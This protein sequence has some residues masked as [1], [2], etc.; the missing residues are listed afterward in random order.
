MT[1]CKKTLNQKSKSKIFIKKKKYFTLLYTN[2]TF[3]KIMSCLKN[4]NTNIC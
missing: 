4:T 3:L 2:I 1:L